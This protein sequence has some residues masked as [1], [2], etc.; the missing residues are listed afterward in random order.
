MTE[1]TL[2]RAVQ[3]GRVHIV[4]RTLLL[5]GE[6]VRDEITCRRAVDNR[7]VYPNIPGPGVALAR[8]TEVGADVL[9]GA[10]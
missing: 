4:A 1:T 3:V 7:W 9:A 10:R 5:D 6:P 2:L 8:L